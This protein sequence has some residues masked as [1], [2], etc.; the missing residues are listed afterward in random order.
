M[1]GTRAIK[2]SADGNAGPMKRLRARLATPPEPFLVT[3]R[4]KARVQSLVDA[5]GDKASILNVGAGATYYGP[6]VVNVD[7][8]DSGTT[9]VIASALAL[10]FADEDADLVILQ[11]VLEHVSDADQTLT[12]CYRVLK[13]GGLFYT[14]MPFLQPYH[15]SPIDMRRSTRP[16]LAKLCAP[17][18]E[19]ESGIHIGPASTIAWFLRELTARVISG[20]K[21][22]VYAKA[23]T[24]AGWVLFPLK[25]AD[26]ILEKLPH[27]HTVASSCYY[28]GRKK[29]A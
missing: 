7:I 23:F 5:A 28:V 15:E 4:S 20:G 2:P 1:T 29:E 22:N 11:G 16:G 10:P 13:P 9:T 17:L 14:E 26:Y 24:L 25:Y 18:V 3:E 27:L 8:Y 19:V 12:E 21:P 6:R